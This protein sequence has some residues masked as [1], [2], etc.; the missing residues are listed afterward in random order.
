MYGWRA[1][2]GM[3]LPANNTVAEPELGAHAP[4]GVSVHATKVLPSGEPTGERVAS[5]TTALPSATAALA[6]SR[7]DAIVYGCM[8]SCLVKGAAWEREASRGLGSAERPFETAGQTLLAALASLGAR[9]LAI[10]SPYGDDVAHLVPGYFVQAGYEVVANVNRASL[11][12]SHVVVGTHP[13]DL[14]RAIAALPPA[15]ALCILATDLPTF[16]IVEH[17]ER[18]WGGPV[19]T[20]NLAM[21]WWLLRT[22][23][24]PD[25]VPGIG[26]LARRPGPGLPRGLAVNA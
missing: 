8:K 5:M 14:F 10:F 2:L 18:T 17:L 23:G 6:Y 13:E 7:V 4:D 3:V 11:A 1:K 15:D 22:A 26:S 24:V 19:V 9:R 20:S 12:D 16:Q 25:E 21:F